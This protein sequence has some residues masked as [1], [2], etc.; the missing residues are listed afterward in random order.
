MG[1][2]ASEK[3]RKESMVGRLMIFSDCPYITE[4]LWAMGMIRLL[5]SPLR[6]MAPEAM[7][8]MTQRYLLS[9]KSE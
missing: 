5:S 3:M 1:M 8:M 9:S 6:I 2:L 7:A 4:S